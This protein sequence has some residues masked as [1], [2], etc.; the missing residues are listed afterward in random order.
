MNEECSTYSDCFICILANCKWNEGVCFEGNTASPRPP[1]DWQTLTLSA[2]FCGDP[3]NLCKNY[4]GDGRW[5]LSTISSWNTKSELADTIP[6]GYF[7]QTTIEN[8]RGPSN[9]G[10]RGGAINRPPPIDGFTYE[11]I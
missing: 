3:L 10:G 11:V 1:T 2:Q 4:K 9:G 7:C 8:D 5:D 6:P